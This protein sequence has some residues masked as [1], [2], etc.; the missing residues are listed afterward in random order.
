MR[1]AYLFPDTHIYNSIVTHHPSKKHS[2]SFARR[3]FII[4]RNAI[5]TLSCDLLS[6]SYLC[7]SNNSCAIVIRLHPLVVICFQIP[8]FALATTV[9]CLLPTRRCSCDL[10]SNSYL[11]VSNNSVYDSIQTDTNVV[12]CFQIPIFALATT[13]LS[14]SVA[15]K[16][17]CDLLSNSYLCVSNNSSLVR[18]STPI[19]L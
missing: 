18:L 17:G 5:D 10:L 6:N 14:A 7:V 3:T 9:S 8:I 13:V 12:I 1:G 19:S 2:K 15:T 11:C 16:G 4:I